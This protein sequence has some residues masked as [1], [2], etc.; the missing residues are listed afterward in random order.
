MLNINFQDH[1]IGNIYMTITTKNEGLKGK[2][3]INEPMSKHTSWRVGGTADNLY[4]PYDVSDL[5]RFLTQLNADEP[6][7]W[8]GLGSNLLV[9]DGGIKGTVIAT[10]KMEDKI[11]M[12]SP[13][14]LRAGA[15]ISCAKLAKYSVKKGL[16]GAEFLIGIPGTFGGALAMNAGAFGSE[17]WDI[18]RSI[19]SINRK[20]KEKVRNKDEF[21]IDY[22]SVAKPSDEWF[23]SAILEL[24]SDINHI[25]QN[26]IRELLNRRIESQ[27]IGE[28]S[29]GS[30]FRNPDDK[31]PAAKLI[32]SCELKGKQIGNASVS[33]KHA[34]F[35]INTGNA[36]AKDIET[37]IY[38]IQDVVYE[39][40]KI[41]LM[42]EVQIVGEEI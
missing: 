12:I 24:D 39:K 36:S 33:E 7:T 40:Y 9:R 19:K 26:K 8:I 37:L 10:K 3:K 31:N 21:T 42:P 13:T 5:K 23:L 6:I 29:C 41:K 14:E 4:F 1:E 22:R 30:V 15:G 28:A 25:G 27:P 35:I 11:E 17:T 20:G 16:T 2:L 18:V 34:N 32:D 38:Y